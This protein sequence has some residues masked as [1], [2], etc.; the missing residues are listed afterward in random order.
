MYLAI[1]KGVTVIEVAII[2]AVLGGVAALV[3][4]GLVI[5]NSF[6]RQGDDMQLKHEAQLTLVEMAR[7]IRN[8]IEFTE[9]TTDKF[10]LTTYNIKGGYDSDTNANLFDDVNKNIITY[11]FVNGGDKSYLEKTLKVAGS[12]ITR[13]MLTGKISAPTPTVPLSSTTIPAGLSLKD[14][15]TLRIALQLYTKSKRDGGEPVITRFNTNAM[16]RAENQ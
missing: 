7:D 12:T 16:K 8:A 6:S 4:V 14:V 11:R 13:T 10:T 2:V 15:S 3:N 1:R 9:V 5:L